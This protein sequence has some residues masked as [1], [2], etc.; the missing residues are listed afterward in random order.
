MKRTVFFV[1][2]LLA[3]QVPHAPGFASSPTGLGPV[4]AGHTWLNGRVTRGD[5]RGRVVLVDVFTFECINCVR[6]T[7]NLQHLYRTYGRRDLEIV[8]VH[9][10]RCQAI[11]VG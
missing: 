2:A 9:T 6:I 5:L 10:L 4:L 8:A 11:K 3:L 7:P 1:G